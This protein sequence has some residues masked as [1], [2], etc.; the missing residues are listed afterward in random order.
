MLQNTHV[1]VALWVGLKHLLN[2]P[3]SVV[4]PFQ[5][6]LKKTWHLLQVAGV[7]KV[8]LL[9]SRSLKT[10]L[11]MVILT[12]NSFNL[13]LLHTW[14]NHVVMIHSILHTRANPSKSCLA[15]KRN[16]FQ[17]YTCHTKSALETNLL[18]TWKLNMTWYFPHQDINMEHQKKMAFMKSVP[19]EQMT[20]CLHEYWHPASFIIFL[21]S[22]NGVNIGNKPCQH[23]AG[24]SRHQ[25]G[26]QGEL[27][28]NKKSP[29][30]YI[31]VKGTDSSFN[32]SRNIWEPYWYYGSLLNKR[33]VS[34]KLLL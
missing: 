1:P 8:Q 14:N 31:L 29:T 27:W 21:L 6:A 26:P 25:A 3:F 32:I 12:Y 9:Q 10:E 5:Q 11:D 33:T 34:S 30:L 20:A 23:Y 7:L 24:R 16:P 19:M 17:Q 15:E 4:W 22:V 2:L 28:H 18:S 13:T